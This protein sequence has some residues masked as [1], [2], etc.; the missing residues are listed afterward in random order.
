MAGDEFLMMWRWLGQIVDRKG[1]DWIK[2]DIQSARQVN[3]QLQ[4]VD[5]WI[6][7]QAG[8]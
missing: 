6:T 3:P 2:A 8:S 7:S 1:V 5:Q 4:T